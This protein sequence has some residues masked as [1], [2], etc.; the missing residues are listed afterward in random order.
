VSPACCSRVEREKARPGMPPQRA[1]RE[2][3]CAP[4]WGLRPWGWRAGVLVRVA[5]WRTGS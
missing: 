4:A 1:A 5:R 3:A 2:S